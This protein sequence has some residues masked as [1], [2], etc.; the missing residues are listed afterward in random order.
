MAYLEYCSNCGTLNET[1]KIDGR[2]RKVCPDCGTVH[3][4]NPRP[5]VT[6]IAVQGSKLLLVKRA[7]EPAIG[8]WCLPGG[9]M[10]AGESTLESARRELLEETGLS[11]GELQFVD[12]CSQP[13]GIVGDVL[14]FAY[15]ADQISGVI[16]AGD[17][18]LEAGYFPLDDLPRIVFACHRE[19]IEKYLS[20]DV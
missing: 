8:E 10:E 4:H 14:V 16:T 5:A 17:D 1:R 2:M 13:G 6:V 20:M 7:V 12:F 3:Y 19:L 18:A 11:V 15:Y 9:F